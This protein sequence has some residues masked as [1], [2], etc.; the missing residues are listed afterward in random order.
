MSEQLN[1]FNTPKAIG[2]LRKKYDK[3]FGEAYTQLNVEQKSAVDQIEGPVMVI[4]GP[5]TG[6][7]QIL[8][9]RIGKILRETQTAPHNILCLT[10]TDAA[11]VAMRNR[12]VEII[13]PEG[14]Q[15][16]IFTFHAFCNQVIQENL[17][18]FGEFR[19]LETISEL[20]EVNVYRKIID[21]LPADHSLKRFKGD[22]YFESNRM[23]N[24]FNMMKKENLSTDQMTKKLDDFLERKQDS[25]DFMSKRTWTNKAGKT[26]EKGQF[27]DDKFKAFAKKY[28]PLRAAIPLYDAYVKGMDEAERYDYNDMILWVLREFENNEDMLADYQERYQYFLVDEYQDTNGAQNEILGKLTAYWGEES[29]VFVVGDDDQAIYKFQGANLNNIKDFKTF[30]KP[31]LE[32]LQHNYRS[33][34]LILDAASHLIELNTERLAN[35]VTGALNKKLIGSGKNATI[36]I[37]PKII[38]YESEAH[39]YAALA[40]KLQNLF[41]QNT[42]PLNEVAVIYR[43]HKQVDKLSTVL[44]KK[45][46]PFS[47]KKKVNILELP[48]IKNIINILRYLHEEYKLP[49]DGE[50]RIFE[51]LH[52]SYFK[53]GADNIAKI[54]IHINNA[55][56]DLDWRDVIAD[57]IQLGMIDIT[58]VDEI[59]DVSDMLEGWLSRMHDV[60]IQVLF[61]E[62]LNQ[63]G[64]LKYIMKHKEKSW[65]LQTVSTFFDFLKNESA[66]E[67]SLNLASLIEM[68]DRMDENK[69]SLPINK[70]ISSENGINFITAHSAK[71]LEFEHVYMLGCTKKTWDTN[72]KSSYQYAYPDNVNEDIETNEEDERRLFYVAMTRAKTHLEISFS[73]QTEEGK[74]LGPS[75]FVDQLAGTADIKIEYVS[76]SEEL[77]QDFYYQFFKAVPREVPLIEK[78]LIDNWFKNYKLSVTHLNKYLACPLTFYFEAILRVP[79][80]RNAATGFGNA[81]HHAL[82]YFFQ[83][84]ND[85]KNQPSDLLINKFRSGMRKYKSHFTEKEYVSYGVYGVKI[86]KAYYIKKF[87]SWNKPK[88][89]EL[90]AKLIHA[91][92]AGVPIKGLL[93]RV[94]IYKDYIH[95]VD[96]KT[97]N[98]TKNSTKKKLDVPTEWNPEGGDYWRQITF[99]KMLVESDTKFNWKFGSA[100]IDFVEPNAD[101]GEF[102]SKRF[103]VSPAEIELVGNQVVETYDNIKNYEFNKTCENEKCYWCNFVKND[104]VLD[105]SLDREE[106]YEATME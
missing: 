50:H 57:D 81:I 3:S 84:M 33:S 85:D 24:L 80:A 104:F 44:D 53:I 74:E 76:V 49:H 45:E 61:E 35:T 10:F 55:N 83:N 75:Q 8:A 26:Y 31:K 23:R 99:Y 64:I 4:A 11:T 96:Y 9:V 98:Y 25:E 67:P 70:I 29:N 19:Q 68:L 52:Y 16:H 58:N 77:R 100:D 2:N 22:R 72:Y 32:V 14:H 15:V 91:E 34:Q 69:I 88:R 21:N 12:L 56:G 92:Y 106:E 105:T 7:T 36:Q 28:D 17:G 37:I 43:N 41:H 93:D 54:A 71:G 65:L 1:I 6:K 97:G 27:R 42:V 78:D 51:I 79:T 82:E 5:G 87:E 103:S 59:L 95:V 89:F 63:A 20:E 30:F 47:I 46:I 38:S 13:G 66:K 102:Y 94:D 86:L 62:I 90:E 48:I 18:I 39:E 101:T 40:E 60:T 73:N